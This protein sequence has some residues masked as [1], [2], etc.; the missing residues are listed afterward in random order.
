MNITLNSELEQL[1]QS[2]FELGEY[3]TI[4][5]LLKDALFSL[6]ERKKRHQLSQKVNDLFNR[7][8]CL[9]HL[10]EITEDDILAEIEAYRSGE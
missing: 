2:Q 6:L 7:T 3:A 4:D 9:P 10:E 1:I 8:Q 5:D